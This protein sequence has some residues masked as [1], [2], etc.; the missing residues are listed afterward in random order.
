MPYIYKVKRIWRRGRRW[1]T[2]ADTD[3]IPRW[4]RA[5]RDRLIKAGLIEETYVDAEG[6]PVRPAGVPDTE[7]ADTSAE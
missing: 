3:R 7:P 6:R 1:I 4:P 5:E 2:G